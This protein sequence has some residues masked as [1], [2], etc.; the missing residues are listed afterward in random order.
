MKQ[1]DQRA[2]AARLGPIDAH[3][4]TLRVLAIDEFALRRGHRYATVVLDPFPF[5]RARCDTPL[6]A[7]WNNSALRVRA[8]AH[9]RVI[10]VPRFLMHD[11]ACVHPARFVPLR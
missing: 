9:A 2:L 10:R 3:W 8:S 6:A 7:A 4:D 5:Y 11:G 1:I